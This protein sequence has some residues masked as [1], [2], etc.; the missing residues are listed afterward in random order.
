VHGAPNYL[1]G[2]PVPPAMLKLSAVERSELDS[3]CM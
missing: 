3:Q 1:I 2:G